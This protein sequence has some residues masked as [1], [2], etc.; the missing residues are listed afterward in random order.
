MYFLIGKASNPDHIWPEQIEHP[1]QKLNTCCFVLYVKCNL[2]RQ[3]RSTCPVFANFKVF[4]LNNNQLVL[5]Y[6]YEKEG[7]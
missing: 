6:N 5:S 3:R 1:N 4:V 7:L 2:T